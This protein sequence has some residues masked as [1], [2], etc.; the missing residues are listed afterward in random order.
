MANVKKV[1]KLITGEII[2]GNMEGVESANGQEIL[3]KQ[4]YQAKEGNIMPYGILDLGNG[5][6]AVQIHP[7]NVIW[8]SPLE[9]FPEIEKAY[10]KATTGIEIQE[11]SKIII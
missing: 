6:G 4:P 10:L 2:F 9:D 11:K 7:M 8:S 5:P 3:I 1:I